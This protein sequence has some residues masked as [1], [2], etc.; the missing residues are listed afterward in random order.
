MAST[1]IQPSGGPTA[2]AS[3]GAAIFVSLAAVAVAL[4]WLFLGMRSVMEIGG[5][6]A[7]GGPFVP[8]RPCPKGIPL[9]MIGGVW[10]GIIACF[11]YA[12]QAFKHHVPNFIGF[13][14]PALFLSLG[15]NFLEYGF[16]PP[17]ENYG[18]VWGWIICGVVFVLMGGLPLL[19]LMGP[20][21]RGFRWTAPQ[22]VGVNQPLKTLAD[23][24]KTR[25][26]RPEVP[27]TIASAGDPDRSK[28][29]WLMIQLV[30]I[31]VGIYV[32]NIGFDAITG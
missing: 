32:G 11:V 12:W 24:M 15:Y 29:I 6:C 21:M 22:G 7:E 26:V 28:M 18:L 2:S 13:A 27:E 19:V 9:V 31:G 14:W 17:V 5:A 3:S 16:D 30:A 10:G 23:A 20:I 4:T 1:S 8:V 25:S